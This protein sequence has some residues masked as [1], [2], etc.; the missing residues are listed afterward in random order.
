MNK[1][2]HKVNFRNIKPT[3]LAAVFFIFMAAAGCPAFAQEDAMYFPPKKTMDSDTMVRALHSPHKATIYSLA[4]PG[5]GQA[6][7]KKYW[8]I[9]IIYAGFGYLGYSIKINNDEVKKFTEAY[10]YV[11]NGDTYPTD[12][13]YVTRYPNT[14]DLLRG[15]DFYRRRVELNIIY[16]AALY[17]LN[18]IDAAVDAHF[19]D[20]DV[21]DNLSLRVEPAII[22][23]YGPGLP[24]T[25]G[26]RLSMN[27]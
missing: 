9:P 3:A 21:S 11:S 7:N 24:G 12:N 25:T 18:V 19:F 15:R 1:P 5:L 8:K 13:E 26:V 2:F 17:I 14:S 22:N 27:F 20:Y 4:L 6:Y 16:S 23:P 10:S